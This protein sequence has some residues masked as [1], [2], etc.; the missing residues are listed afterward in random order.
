MKITFS[1][2]PKIQNIPLVF[3]LF[4]KDNL[5]HTSLFKLL[6]KE[7]QLKL[8][9]KDFDTSIEP[10]L[11]RGKIAWKDSNPKEAKKNLE[12]VLEILDDEKAIMAYAEQAGKGNVLWPLRY[13]L[14]GQEKSP[15]PLTLL[16]ILG[17]TESEKRV[18]KA[19]EMLE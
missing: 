1:A 17:H 14:S 16:A 4:A 12:K 8:I 5:I 7:E 13:V 9:A 15:D 11:E 3:F 18:K 10:K 2:A 6:P 19:I